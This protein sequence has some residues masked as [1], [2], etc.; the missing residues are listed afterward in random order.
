MD[1]SLTSPASRPQVARTKD[2]RKSRITNGSTLLPGVDGRSAWVRRCKDV[3]A[4]HISD[5]GGLD[6]VSAA[7]RSIVRRASVITTELERLEAR[8]AVAGAASPEDID[9]Y[10]RAS[11]SLRR[12]LE[13]VGI[14]RRPR[15]ITPNLSQYL[16][17]KE[18]QEQHNGDVDR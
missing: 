7:E 17:L 4:E 11:N 10:L 2:A 6:N 14:Q 5:L 16:A 8:F 9:L 1:V 18:Q 3:I 15:N 13:S 12:L